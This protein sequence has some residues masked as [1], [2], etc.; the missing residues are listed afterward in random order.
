MSE[1]T[2]LSSI[3]EDFWW[4]VA[5][6]CR[7]ATFFHTPLWTRLAVETY[8]GYSDGTVGAI[9]QDGRRIVLPLVEVGSRGNA[10]M[11]RSTFAD[12]YGG[13]IAD[14][15]ETV[16]DQNSFYGF[17]VA[18]NVAELRLCGNPLHDDREFDHLSTSGAAEDFTNIIHLDKGY[19]SVVAG[20]SKGHK[21]SLTKGLRMGVTVRIADTLGDYETYYMV[22][23]DTLRRWGESARKTYPW[24]LFENGYRL[25]NEYPGLIRLWLA[26]V[27][28]TVVAGAWTFYWNDH[29]D[30]WH[31]ASLQEYFDHCPN[32]VLQTHIIRD[33][34]DRGYKYYDFNPSGGLHGVAKFKDSFG[35]ERI[36]FGR[37]H[38]LSSRLVYSKRFNRVVRRIAKL[39]LAPVRFHH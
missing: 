33:A 9:T 25:S 23:E 34:F 21:S 7:Y 28:E 1:V 20:F 30:W 4:D 14:G 16:S 36:N 13:L 27:G 11:L 6:Q 38:Y 26:E 37:W 3:D 18:N 17:V 19:D 35:S 12:C 32:N 8:D 22:Y 2:F 39:A 10:R 15:P 24:R 29:V 5:E 31:G